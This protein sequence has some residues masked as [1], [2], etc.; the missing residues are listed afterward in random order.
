MSGY[1]QLPIFQQI[2]QKLADVWVAHNIDYKKITLCEHPLSAGNFGEVFKGSMLTNTQDE[3]KSTVVAVKVPKLRSFTQ[4]NDFLEAFCNE[5]KTTLAFDHEHV[6]KCLGFY[7]NAGHSYPHLVMEFMDHGSLE[8]L[9]DESSFSLDVLNSFSLDIA[10]GMGY[11]ANLNITHG[12]LAARNCLVNYNNKSGQLTVKISDFGMTRALMK[13]YEYYEVYHL[14]PE[15]NI[16]LRW[17]A[18]ETFLKRI[19]SKKSDVWSYGVTLWEIYTAT[20]V[21]TFLQIHRFTLYCLMEIL[22]DTN[23]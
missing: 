14:K 23:L 1:I 21:R 5:I 19:F 4:G 20:K 8:N 6:V 3:E 18:P 15:Q 7:L 9:L 11:L 13:D 12:D 17:A 10:R 22:F 16:A 2:E